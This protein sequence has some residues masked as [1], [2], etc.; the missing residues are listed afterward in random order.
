MRNVRVFFKKFGLVKFASHL[1]MNRYMIRAL[2]RSRLPVWYTEGFNPHPYITFAL[3]LS[4]GFESDYEV[5]DMRLTDDTVTDEEV[6]SALAAVLPEGLEVFKAAEPK[7]KPGKI[8]SAAFE[9][10]FEAGDAGFRNA[11][12]EFMHRESITVEKKGKKG[13]I[14]TVELAGR[15]SSLEIT[16]SGA[17]VLMS[18]TLPA[19]GSDNLN[20]QLYLTAA[21]NSGIVLPPYSI[22]RTG[23]YNAA[24]ELFV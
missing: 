13:K 15:F 3:P 4:L 16:L 22:K 19:G 17:G 6:V 21:E 18:I 5:M 14:S 7:E 20:P 8:T 2:R 9:M 24:G 10:F 12:D 1:D 23:L 11:L